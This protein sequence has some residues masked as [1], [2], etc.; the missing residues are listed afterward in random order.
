MKQARVVVLSLLI[1]SLCG[2]FSTAQQNATA[3][4][5]TVPPLI[6]F[7]SVASDEGGGSL[8]GVVNITFS[9]YAAQQG[10]APLWTEAQN[11][12][13]LDATGHYSVQ[14]GITKPN[15]VPTTLFTTGEARWLG[16][17]IA[18]QVEQP[19]VLLL[20]VPYALK[21]GDAAT[22][23]GLPPSAFVLAAPLSGVN[24]TPGAEPGTGQGAPPPSGDV[25][26]TGKVD[27]LPLWD[28]T[29]DIISSVLFQKGT[30]NT[31]KIGINT[32]TPATTLDVKG[33]GTI[34]GTLSLPAN[35]AATATAGK[36][37]QPLNLAAS[38]FNSTSS[39]AVNQTFQW[40]SEPA[41]NNTST[42]SGTLNLL[43]GEGA[44]KP[45]ETGLNIASN[46]QI[47]F[48]TGQIFPGTG[49][50]TITGVNTAA[51]SGLTGGGTSGT[52]NLALTNT[53]AANQ[54]LQW[55][56]SAWACSTISGTVTSVA[57]GL[58]LKGGPITTTG[59]LTIDTAVVPQ[60]GA[61]NT[62][63]GNQTVNG[64]LNATSSGFGISGTTSGAQYSG[65]AGSN[66]AAT[67]AATGVSGTTNSPTGY[68][69]WG[70]GPGIG[71]FGNSSATSG[72]TGVLGATTS[73]TGYGV[74]GSNS[75]QTGV[76]VG[77]YGYSQSPAGYAMEGQNY[78]ATGNAVG[79]YGYSQSPAGYG[80]EGSSSNIGVYG[81]GSVGVNGATSATA[82]A[83]VE[84]IDNATS[85][86]TAGLFEVNQSSAT[87]L[88]GNNGSTTEFKVDAAG[89]VTAAGAVN[90]KGAVS[91]NSFQ[92]GGELFAYGN[93]N[94]NNAFLGFAGGQAG[95]INQSTVPFDTA[96]G[97]Y[98]LFY[99]TGG[100]NTA[101]GGNTLPYNTTGVGNTAIGALTGHAI[102]GSYV[103]GSNNTA[104]GY[105]TSFST[106]TLSN[107]TAIGAWA[108]VSESNALVLGSINGVNNATASTNVG[109]GTS[110][111]GHLLDVAGFVAFDSTGQNNGNGID[112]TFG[113]DAGEG[114]SSS[115][116]AGPNQYGLDLYTDYN[117]R[118]SIEQHGNVGIGTTSPD[119]LLTVN[120]SAD[121]PGGGSWGTYSDGRLKTVNGGFTDGLS[122]VM[123]IRPVHYR[124][125]PDNAMGIRDTDEHIGVVA[126]DVQKV[127]P[128]AVTENSKGYLLVN[129][130]PIIWTM[131]NAIKEQQGEFQREQAV[132]KEQ[133]AE[134]A[135][136]LRLI[137][138]QQS[139]LRAQGAA[140]KSLQAEVRET[141]ESVWKVK[142]QVCVAQPTLLAAK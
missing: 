141:R 91:G 142:A 54:V 20:S 23:G 62:F 125:K 80:V 76:A 69:V 137:K 122:Q 17:R 8:S 26:G 102:D 59:T 99:D 50:G 5:A 41:G 115:R 120:G 139:L 134:L 29:S 108:E 36:N 57:T 64:T 111:P 110:T 84:G 55:S 44:T 25:T 100:S 37:S 58:G 87:I 53:C 15:G 31:A 93:Y 9:L 98:A 107:A 67:G 73:T 56:G 35:G 94:N 2:L 68:G 128:E 65:V 103:T 47:T 117:R 13:Q 34:R 118:I 85:G 10:G 86:G 135:K 124:Y 114:M 81:T 14:L 121:K 43:F 11:N 92:I 33:A 42:P 82:G 45:S 112:L 90:A 89:D 30:G 106:G 61:V 60:L 16:V 75:S 21:A 105:N 127:I 104:L 126:Q 136:A 12:I 18:E 77:V 4:S 133:R 51:G 79:V 116:T 52:L 71:V 3:A 113:V 38:A 27:Y 78:A 28:S 109:I 138:Q 131:L 49:N 6:P 1:V 70:Q 140:M 123:K 72:G 119:N 66:T 129:N 32:A 88:Q 39:T 40:Q 132:S 130:D 101:V 95:G 22:V 63:T 74:T 83:G 24:P 19:R 97:A 46:G 96:V 7:S 48:A